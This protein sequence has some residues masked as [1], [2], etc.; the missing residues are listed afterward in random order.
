MAT[1]GYNSTRIGH[2]KQSNLIAVITAS[3][4]LT[5]AVW[6]LCRLVLHAQLKGNIARGNTDPQVTTI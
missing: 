4:F 2:A 5:A 3:P 6:L 1:S